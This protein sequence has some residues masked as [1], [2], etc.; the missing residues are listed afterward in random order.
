MDGRTEQWPENAMHFGMW[1]NEKEF[2]SERLWIYIAFWMKTIGKKYFDFLQKDRLIFYQSGVWIAKQN[3]KNKR[4]FRRNGMKKGTTIISRKIKWLL[5]KS[6]FSVGFIYR[7]WIN[8][9]IVKFIDRERNGHMNRRRWHY[10]IKE[11]FY[12]YIY[13]IPHANILFQWSRITKFMPNE[14]RLHWICALN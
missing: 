6:F 10:R 11:A 4:L 12:L 1:F 9:W 13:P 14:T 3:G 5:S 8:S 7:F 2:I